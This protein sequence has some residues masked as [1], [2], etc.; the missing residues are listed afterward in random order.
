VLLLFKVLQ[1]LNCPLY[2]SS[3]PAAQRFAPSLSHCDHVCMLKDIL[4]MLLYANTSGQ[5]RC[6]VTQHNFFVTQ[7]QTACSNKHDLGAHFWRRILVDNNNSLKAVSVQRATALFI[8]HQQDKQPS[9][10][11][12]KRTTLVN[13]TLDDHEQRHSWLF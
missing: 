7:K 13:T 8:S 10:T 6:F 2:L 9:N 4:A 3:I 5:N 1:R 11:T 12:K